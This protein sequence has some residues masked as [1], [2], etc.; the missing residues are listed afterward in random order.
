MCEGVVSIRPAVCTHGEVKVLSR[1]ADPK[2]KVS[3]EPASPWEGKSPASSKVWG[4][5][6]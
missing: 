1:K 4:P 6:A 2:I 3:S 5:A